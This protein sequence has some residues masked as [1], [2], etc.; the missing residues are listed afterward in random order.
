MQPPCET[1]IR[2]TADV[3]LRR[4]KAVCKETLSKA[5]RTAA[6]SLLEQME[7]AAKYRTE[8]DPLLPPAAEHCDERD[9]R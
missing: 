3:K 4:P 2:K 1:V 7:T 6:H 9:R 5:G 8:R